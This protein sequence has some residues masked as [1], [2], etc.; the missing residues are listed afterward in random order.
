MGKEP[1]NVQVELELREQEEFIFLRDV[2]GV[3]L[4]VEPHVEEPRRSRLSSGPDEELEAGEDS[5]VGVQSFHAALYAA[6]NQNEASANETRSLQAEL[7]REKE[8]VKE[9]WK[10][11]CAQLNRFDEALSNKE[12]DIEAL[13]ERISQLETF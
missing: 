2:D 8:R 10:L 11:N 13:K 5:A 9:M 7:K 3:F 1:L 4:E 6:Q 12:A